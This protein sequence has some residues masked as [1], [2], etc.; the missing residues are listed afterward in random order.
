[1]AIASWLR[2]LLVAVAALLVLAAMMLGRRSQQLHPMVV[3][4][5]YAT[6]EL[7]ARLTELYRPSSPRCK[8]TGWFRL[9]LNNTALEDPSDVRCFA[10]QMSTVYDPL[11]DDYYNARG[12][13][14]SVP[15]FGSTQG[16]RYPDPDRK[17][18][19]YMDK[20]VSRLERIGYHD[21]KNLFGAPYDFRYAVAPVGH[22]SRVGLAFFR[23]LKRLVEKA[24]RLNGGRPVTIV[25]HSF[26]G[27][28][29]Y[30][31]LLRRPLSWRK[32]F[33]RRF[34]PVAAPWGGVVTVM[35]ALNS[36]N[37]L[38]LPF[39]DPLALKAEYRSLE[40]SVWLL[41]S[42]KVFPAAQ[43]LVAT[44]SR[45]YSAH[46]MADFLGAIG[47]REAIRPYRTRALPLFSELP[48]PQVPVACVV[49][50]GRD[51]LE[52]MVYPG[53]DFSVAPTMV[54]GDGDG[55]VNL[56]SLVAVDPA[57]RRSRAGASAHFKMV[58]VSNVSHTDLLV[59][60]CA[61]DILIDAIQ[62]P[63]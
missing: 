22:R 46:D 24:S 52:R 54:M 25:A 35:L 33:V 41:P 38:A 28:L 16:L 49:G 9:Y 19:S 60:D 42:P 12:V 17:D 21:G 32:R 63:N 39:V 40:S 56:A 15:F 44:K 18:F 53:D 20:F 45:N 34:V 51:T 5:G 4:P 47:L 3:V 14:T 57:W 37:N 6:N 13:E 23:R 30:Q 1:M 59:E 11:S 55:L 29:A 36:G 50:V 8:K 58:K 61:L 10:E 48:S 62:R 27:P 43:P 31:F 7:D 26:G 2:W